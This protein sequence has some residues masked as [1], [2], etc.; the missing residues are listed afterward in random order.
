MWQLFLHLPDEWLIGMLV[1]S[2]GLILMPVGLLHLRRR[3]KPHRRLRVLPAAGLSAWMCL[4]LLTAVEIGFALLYD[5]TDSFDMTNVSR[6]WFQIHAEPDVRAFP[7]ADATV[8]RYRDNA[9]LPRQRLPGVAHTLFLG[10]SFTFG[11]GVADVDARFTNRLRTA[12]DPEKH[13]ISNL[14]WPGTDLLW[15]EEVLKQV[16]AAG[17]PVDRAVYVLC[18]NDIEAFHDPRMTRS[19]EQSRFD[20]PGLLFRDTYFFNWAY[21]RAQMLRR[22]K[23]GDYYSFVRADYD[24]AA[25]DRFSAVLARTADLCWTH[26]AR[27]SVVIFPFLHS[28]GPDDPFRVVHEKLAARCGELRIEHLDLRPALAAH[29]DETLTVN[30]FDAHPNERAHELAAEA[31]REAWYGRE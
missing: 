6:R 21:F 14:A 29:R 1:W 19:I 4:V 27:F 10:D 8:I 25:F 7:L 15:V 9:D 20:P 16:F 31:I 5:T 28:L 26:N 30:P 2:I 22:S 3:W 23:E 11:H 12:L 17:V 24:G 18:L 13:R